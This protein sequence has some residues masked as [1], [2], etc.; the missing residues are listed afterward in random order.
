MEI[1]ILSRRPS[2][3]STTRLKEA[4]IARG[5]EARVIDYLRCYMNIAVAK[6]AVLFRGEDLH[7]DA[8]VPRIGATHTFYGTA[9]VRQF[10]MTGVYAVNESQAITRSRDKLR[11]MQ[12][13]TRAGVAMP[14]TGFAHSTQDIDGLLDVAGGAPVIVKLLEGTQGL[15]GRARRDPEGGRVGDRGLPSARRQHPRPGVHQGVE[16][17]RCARLRHRRQGGGG[18]DAHRACR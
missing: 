12:L 15:G 14:V 11:S 2:L 5:H 8:I 9:V 17:V 18:D 13:L 6:P 3:Y 4:A 16:G 7:F 10:E 1:G